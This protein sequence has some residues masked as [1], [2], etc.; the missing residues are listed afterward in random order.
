MS[1]SASRWPVADA[2]VAGLAVALA[3]DLGLA[4][5]VQFALVHNPVGIADYERAG[6]SPTVTAVGTSAPEA[7]LGVLAVLACAVVLLE[8]LV[9]RFTA[10]GAVSSP[11]T[12]LRVRSAAAVAGL[13]LVLGKFLEDPH[14][15]YLGYGAFL[16]LGLA[17]VLAVLALVTERGASRTV[18]RS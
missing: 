18:G 13:A 5:W 14:P 11:L 2:I 12:S 7:V 8:L 10:L 15:S 3:L 1:R 16:A 4:P 9:R 6:I 17:L